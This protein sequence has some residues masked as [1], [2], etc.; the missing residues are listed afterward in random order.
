MRSELSAILNQNYSKGFRPIDYALLIY[1]SLELILV[2]VFMPGRQGWP[3]LLWFYMAVIALVLFMGS[4][5]FPASGRFWK[6]IR[7]GYPMLL[8]LM[9]YE[10]V[11]FQ[12]P[13]LNGKMFDSQIHGLE[14][15]IFGNDPGF[16][17]QPYMQIWLNEIMNLAYMSYY[18]FLP[19][20][21]IMLVSK[22]NFRA[23]EQLSFSVSF[24]FY[25][26]YILFILYPVAGP[27]FYLAD[28]YY[29]PL[30]GP[31]I[32]PVVLEIV[33]N[34]GL[35]GGAMPSSHCA[36]AFVVVWIIFKEF[37]KLRLPFGIVFI[38]LCMATVYGRYHYISDV[39]AGIAVGMACLIIADRIQN[40][41]FKKII[42]AAVDTGDTVLEPAQIGT[43]NSN[44]AN[45]R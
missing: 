1:A 33:K 26:C 24:T 15:L 41:Y 17:L 29:L 13:M 19:V 12:I 42:P 27:R 32:T 7:L 20:A 6:T 35:Y 37:R 44:I 9:L 25:A 14:K 8:F 10:S 23:L 16:L 5:P 21:V 22:N 38:L 3:Y 31:Y 40:Q 39:V 43:D 18:F 30:I 34:G 11:G 28:I 2:A 4:A 45:N 36:V